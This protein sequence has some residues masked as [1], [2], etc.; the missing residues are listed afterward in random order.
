MTRVARL[1]YE[2]DVKQPEIARRLDLSQA[3]VSRLLRRA[4]REQIVRITVSVPVGA[5]PE[6]EEG[7]ERRYDLK[8][9]IV[10]DTVEEDEERL[11]R[12]LGA[13]AAHYVETT[14]RSDE[15]VGIASYASLLGMVNALH[16]RGGPGRHSRDESERV[17]VVQLNGGVG[18]PSAEEHAT[19]VTRRL[20]MLLDAEAIF[21]PAPGLASS[22]QAK[23][24]FLQDPFVREALKACGRVTM[25]LMGIAP[26]DGGGR[27]SL[28]NAFT[29][30]EVEVL[31]DHGAAGFICHRFFNEQGEPVHTSLDSRIL[32]MTLDQ[33]RRVE[34]RVGISGG[35]RRLSAIRAA[36]AGRWVNILITDRLTAARLLE[37]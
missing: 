17:Q 22:A 30:H 10:V 9:A 27:T 26:L 7:L 3:T 28:M 19:Q 2:G 12:D 15:V 24:M 14:L 32:A 29:P 18:N 31:R 25:A 6:Q 20:A 23:E 11:L 16:P 35:P 21:L 4:E 8:K 37:D 36:L 1:Y 13:A 33:L 5:F 34:R